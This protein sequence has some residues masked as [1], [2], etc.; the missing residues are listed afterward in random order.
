MKLLEGEKAPER[1]VK[2]SLSLHLNP[3]LSHFT[4]FLNTVKT[5][6]PISLPS[7]FDFSMDLLEIFEQ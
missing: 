6:Y 7:S 3:S 5:S 1:S 4:S 2:L